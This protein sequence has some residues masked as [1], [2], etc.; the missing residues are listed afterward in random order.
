M[1]FPGSCRRGH[2]QTSIS[3]DT[4]E[5]K[6]NFLGTY[7]TRRI[8]TYLLAYFTYLFGTRGASSYAAK[9]RSLAELDFPLDL[10]YDYYILSTGFVFFSS[11][12][13]QYNYIPSYDLFLCY[14]RHMW[15]RLD[16]RGQTATRN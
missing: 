8:N 15:R 12:V 13:T 6:R 5:L 1:S 11:V 16:Q 7:Q 14:I 10:P 9:H 2:K 4:P 3:T